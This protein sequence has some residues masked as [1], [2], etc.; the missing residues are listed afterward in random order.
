MDI[1]VSE[2][3]VRQ[4]MAMGF[5][6]EKDVRMALRMAR[7]DMNEAL[8]VL[9]NETPVEFGPKPL[10]EAVSAVDQTIEVNMTSDYA[11]GEDVLSAPVQADDG[12]DDAFPVAELRELEG[13]VFVENWN[14]PYKRDESLGVCL[15]AAIQMARS[16]TEDDKPLETNQHAQR[17]MEH[18]LPECFNKLLTA[19]AVTRWNPEILDGVY[20]M[21][22][23][24]IEL[25]A[26]RLQ[27]LP[28]PVVLLETLASAFDS[29]CEYYQRHAVRSRRADKIFWMEQ[30]RLK[31]GHE[32]LAAQS[33]SGSLKDPHG[34][35]CNIINRFAVNSGFQALRKIALAE[36]NGINVCCLFFRADF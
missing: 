27:Y 14:I 9:F 13:R 29:E 2:D 5:P 23:L 7:N 18:C 31:F 19:N 24:L 6:E 20:G 26:A 30:M 32:R 4:L 10:C 15:L 21:C 8:S 28:L 12:V 11:C 33:P 22:C 25:T 34:M 36:D 16:A 35:L 17:F 3:H 1:E